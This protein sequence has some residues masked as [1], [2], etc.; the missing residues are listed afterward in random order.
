API[1]DPDYRENSPTGH[2]TR[3]SPLR[4]SLKA[5]RNRDSARNSCAR[6]EVKVSVF[7]TQ[8]KYWAK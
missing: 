1:S 4:H 8:R 5:D 6:D 2:G 3:D 7:V